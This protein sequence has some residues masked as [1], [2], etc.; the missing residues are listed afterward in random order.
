MAKKLSR[1]RLAKRLQRERQAARATV[2]R[3]IRRRG[4]MGT[5]FRMEALAVALGIPSEAPR[6]SLRLIA[7]KQL[8]RA[9]FDAAAFKRR[10]IR[11]ASQD[12]VT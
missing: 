4:A 12:E 10:H 9:G 2:A 1:A 7:R 11:T 3:Y 5:A 6:G 8:E